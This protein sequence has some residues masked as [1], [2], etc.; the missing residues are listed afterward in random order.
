VVERTNLF[1]GDLIVREPDVADRQ[2]RIVVDERGLSLDGAFIVPKEAFVGAA[3]ERI[4][5][6]G[7]CRL[8][9]VYG[10]RTFAKVAKITL[11]VPDDASAR[12]VTRALGIDAE[13]R[14][15][16]V[17]FS[18]SWG[19]PE[20]LLPSIAFALV[21]GLLI[22]FAASLNPLAW[23][24]MF[25]FAL[26]SYFF[27][28][29][30]VDRTTLTVGS[31]GVLRERFARNRFVSFGEIARVMKK[32]G[33]LFLE[34][35]DGGA[36]RLIRRRVTAADQDRSP[37][38]D[39]FVELLALQ[40]QS[41]LEVRHELARAAEDDSF[42]ARRGRPP[43]KWIDDLRGAPRTGNDYRSPPVGDENLPRLVADGSRS[44]DARVG[45][46]IA[47]RAREGE[48]IVPRLRVAA[49]VT[50]SPQL[51]VALEKIADGADDG[52]IARSIV[53]L[54]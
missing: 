24:V 3:I 52:E 9:L 36:M 39:L 18:Q 31:D 20:R 8:L 6:D 37:D 44:P 16:R 4:R 21:L 30:R 48:A 17:S 32:D 5:D 15:T 7:Q 28:L 49:A 33:G 14:L 1:E 47:L 27:A 10:D 11:L 51:R 42:V 29:Q 13:Q 25:V 41:A 35:C 40:I 53:K 38:L 12:A 43:K 22:V 19:L 54:G 23:L 34:L 2:A 50:A 45:A 26:A 46:A